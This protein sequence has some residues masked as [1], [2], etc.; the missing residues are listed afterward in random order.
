MAGKGHPLPASGE[1]RHDEIP[2]NVERAKG[3]GD[4][5]APVVQPGPEAADPDGQTYRYNPK[6]RPSA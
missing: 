3:V 4:D 6:S 1:A 2:E 5:S